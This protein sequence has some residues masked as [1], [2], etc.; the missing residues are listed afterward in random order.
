MRSGTSRSISTSRTRWIWSPI[1]PAGR[2]IATRTSS[3]RPRTASTRSWR[4]QRLDALL[5]PGPSSAGIAAK[6]G[7]PTVIVPFGFVPNTPAGLPAGLQREGSA[8]RRGLH[9]HGVHGA[10]L[11]RAGVCVRAGHQAARA[12]AGHAVGDRGTEGRGTKVRRYI[13][14]TYVARGSWLRDNHSARSAVIGSTR[15][16]RRAGINTAPHAIANSNATTAA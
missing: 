15:V 16:A 3:W 5:F 12:A 10:A 2:P 7:H 8:L 13:S 6:A 1:A 14:T 11:D 4:V 9:G